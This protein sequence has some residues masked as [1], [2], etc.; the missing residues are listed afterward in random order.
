MNN[1]I[2]VGYVPTACA[3]VGLPATPQTRVAVAD[4]DSSTVRVYS[5]EGE[6]NMLHQVRVALCIYMPV[7]VCVDKGIEIKIVCLWIYVFLY[8]CGE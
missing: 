1:I 8:V 7:G 2:T 3:W 6:Q 4:Q 5:S